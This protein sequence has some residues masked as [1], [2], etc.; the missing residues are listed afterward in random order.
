MAMRVGALFSGGKDSTYAAYLLQ[1][2]GWEVPRLLTIIPRSSESY[3]F[4]HPN[5]RWTSLQSNAMGIEQRRVDTDGT[6]EAE[7]ED[8]ERLLEGEDVDGFVSGAI[9][10]DYQWSRMNEICEGLGRPLFSPLWRRPQRAILEDM[11]D[12]GFRTIVVGVYAEGLDDSWLGREI[13]RESVDEL[14]ELEGRFGIS[15]SGEGGVIETFVVDGPN[16]SSAI[17]INDAEKRVSRDS[18]VYDI[19]DACLS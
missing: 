16:F 9:A 6:K 13:T 7:L 11:L 17:A 4:H 10:S 2:Q 1:Q 19:K 12:A 3:M 5:V 14:L 15:I 8:L 18:G